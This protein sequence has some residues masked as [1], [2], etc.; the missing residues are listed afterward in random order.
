MTSE[1]LYDTLCFLPEVV[2]AEERYEK[3]LYGDQKDKMAVASRDA[4]QARI[5][6][7]K[8]CAVY[9]PGHETL[10]RMSLA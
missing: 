1:E 7:W 3:A 6:A 5:D 10:V 4:N 2:E 9:W 8:W